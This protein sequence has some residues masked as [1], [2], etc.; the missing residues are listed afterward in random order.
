[1]EA[2]VIICRTDKPTGRKGKILFI[3]AVDEVTRKQAQSFL[4]PKHIERIVQAYRSFEHE[5]GF[6]RVVSLSNV[7]GKNSNLSIPRY[8]QPATTNGVNGE[9]EVP[10]PEVVDEWLASSEQ[11]RVSM[12]DLFLTLEEAGIGK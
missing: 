10:L 11:L 8:V 1:M 2:C 5:E 6:A 7:K 4:E 12:D 3:N 9:S